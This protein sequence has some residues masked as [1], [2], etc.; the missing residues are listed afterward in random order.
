MKAISLPVEGL[1][2]E[3]LLQEA[4]GGV[5]FLTNGGQVRF[6]VLP[7][8]EGDEEIIALCGNANFMAYLTECEQRARTRPRKSLR[9]I[10]NR[11]GSP[12]VTPESQQDGPQ[13]P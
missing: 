5:V 2:V 6:A 7:A 11:Y 1:T 9:E 4:A 13:T 10:R 8:D 3:R 12:P